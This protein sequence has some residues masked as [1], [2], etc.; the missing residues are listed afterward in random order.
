[1]ANAGLIGLK[2]KKTKIRSSADINPDMYISELF[3]D[4]L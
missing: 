2:A 4:A 3:Y 1:M